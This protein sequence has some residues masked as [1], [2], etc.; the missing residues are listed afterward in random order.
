MTLLQQTIENAWE[1]RA[2]LSPRSAPAE[3]RDAV[4]REWED[5]RRLAANE[6]YMQELLAHYRVT[7]EEPAAPGERA[8][9]SGK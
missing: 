3:V 8:A 6:R 7:I 9:A 5:S 4:R 1:N 2:E